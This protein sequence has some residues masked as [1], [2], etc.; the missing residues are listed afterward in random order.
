M[1]KL[2]IYDE[3]IS[4][5]GDHPYPDLRNALDRA[6]ILLTDLN[7]EY[8]A[9]KER[10]RE[11]GLDCEQDEWSQLHSDRR[12][13]QARVMALEALCATK[14]YRSRLV[15]EALA[16]PLERHFFRVAQDELTQM[17]FENIRRIAL[18]R[19]QDAREWAEGVKP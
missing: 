13:Q 10:R 17:E 5:M 18:R 14:K 11:S 12:S 7:Y 15:D 9:L 6:K 1:S 4:E 16:T 8:N 3:T 2:E 19:D